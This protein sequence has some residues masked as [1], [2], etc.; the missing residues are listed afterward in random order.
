MFPVLYANSSYSFTGGIWILWRNSPHFQFHNF[1]NG[2][3]NYNRLVTFN[4]GHP[5]HHILKK[6]KKLI[7]NIRDK[8]SKPWIIFGDFNELSSLHEKLAFSIGNYTRYNFI[9]QN[10]LI[11]LGFLGKLFT[12]HNSRENHAATFSRLDRDG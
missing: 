12:W 4:Y 10:N 2:N 9:N 11:D 7:G 5:H 1:T 3:Y 6:L 8:I